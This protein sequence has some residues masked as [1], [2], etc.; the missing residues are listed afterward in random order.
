MGLASGLIEEGSV[1]GTDIRIARIR[2]GLKQY[3]LA[4]RAGLRQNELSLIENNRATATPE[5][6][7]R[8]AQA[9]GLGSTEAERA[10]AAR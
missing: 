10:R 9:L 4:Q 5:K 2:A 3:E 6:S 7:A 8:I 1:D